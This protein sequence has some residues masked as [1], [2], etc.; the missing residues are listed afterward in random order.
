MIKKLTNEFGLK[1]NYSAW[2]TYAW[3]IGLNKLTEEQYKEIEMHL[4]K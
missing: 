1:E 3:A 4:M 2:A